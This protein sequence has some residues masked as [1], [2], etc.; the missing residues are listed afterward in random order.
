[1]FEKIFRG[2]P[3]RLLLAIPFI[4]VLAGNGR[5]ADRN[6]AHDILVKADRVRS[7]WDS[8]RMTSF[9]TLN[10]MGEEVKEEYRVYVKE[11]LKTLVVF[12]SPPKTKGNILLM[13]GENLWFYVSGTQRE[14]K[15]APLQRLS[16]G[17]SYGDIA[18]LNWGEDYEAEIAG[19]EPLEM[20][21]GRYNTARLEL[22][23]KS[24][25][26]TYNKI[27]LWV[28]EGNHYPRKADIFLKSGM[29]MKTLYFTKFETVRGKPMNVEITFVDHM[30][31]D[32]RTMMNFTGAEEASLPS[33]YF[34]KTM[35]RELSDKLTA[36]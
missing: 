14:L 21:G 8:F 18:R 17:A 30:A 23:A 27:T 5:A 36:E 28:E 3:L 6:N 22:V 32:A 11:G 12:V 24:A 1:M 26:A 33:E 31:K 9:I 4:I 34:L 19:R 10:R 25:G 35:L 2:T 16:G 7:P 15:V 29:M 13:V 20:E